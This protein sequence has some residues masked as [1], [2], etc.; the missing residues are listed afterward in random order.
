MTSFIIMFLVF[1]C[2]WQC[3]RIS[4]LEGRVFIMDGFMSWEQRQSV[5]KFYNE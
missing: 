1:V 5:R 3:Y 2:A 4:I